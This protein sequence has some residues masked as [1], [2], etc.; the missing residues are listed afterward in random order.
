MRRT[1]KPLLTLSGP[2]QA[3]KPSPIQ[4]PEAGR[5][6]I[7]IAALH[8]PAIPPRHMVADLVRHRA[9]HQLPSELLPRQP[10]RARKRLE[11]E[12][13]SLLPMGEEVD[14]RMETV[15]AC[16]PL[17]VLVVQGTGNA[18]MLQPFKIRRGE[19]REK[20]PEFLLAERKVKGCRI[21]NPIQTHHTR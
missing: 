18:H 6:R 14:T 2:P 16:E 20:S 4:L 21:H 19:I 12:E 11:M 15:I 8:H 7:R 3:P 10:Q 17:V 9:L 5:I 13:L 1:G